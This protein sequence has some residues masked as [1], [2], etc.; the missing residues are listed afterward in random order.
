VG[1]AW[2][3][4]VVIALAVVQLG[5]I[6]LGRSRLL[7]GL[8]DDAS[9]T[10]LSRNPV[11]LLAQPVAALLGIVITLNSL[12]SQLRGTTGWKGRRVRGRSL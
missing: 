8:C 5:Y 3:H 4:P 2:A 6:L 7:A 12:Q 11:V 10:R 1:G 9:G